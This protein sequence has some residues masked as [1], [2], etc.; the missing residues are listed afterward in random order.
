M[1]RFPTLPE[2][3]HLSD[4][5]K[6][7]GRG[8]WSL[9]EFHDIVLRG[10]SD[11]SVAEREL[12]A[13]YVSGLNACS[14]CHDSHKMIAGIHGIPESTLSSMVD[15]P[16]NSGV[17]TR[18]QPVLAYL[19]KLTLTPSKIVD[20]DAQAVFDAG[21][22]EQALFDAITVCALFNFMNRIVEGCGVMTSDANLAA[23]RS[24]H[25]ETRE[26]EQPYR[27]FAR[28]MGFSPT[29]AK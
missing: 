9:T 5:F 10:E 27:D 1:S 4:V 23:S 15:D 29:D 13:A 17:S 22:S 7:F 25:E 19:R 2:V 26:S 14:F 24:R 3:P 28:G 20:A 16:E 18:L 12:L 21:V 6:S 8:V 11:W